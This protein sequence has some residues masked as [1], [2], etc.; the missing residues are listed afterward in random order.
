MC[1]K[2]FTT[3]FMAHSAL[4]LSLYQVLYKMYTGTEDGTQ[5]S[6]LI[7]RPVELYDRG[8]CIEAA[9]SYL[10]GTYTQ[11]SSLWLCLCRLDVSW[12][13]YLVADCAKHC[14]TLH[15]YTVGNVAAGRVSSAGGLNTAVV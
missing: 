9:R 5:A 14:R 3:H 15:D 2:C 8:G 12:T 6:S 4:C 13:L 1:N 11:G 7:Y 10:Y